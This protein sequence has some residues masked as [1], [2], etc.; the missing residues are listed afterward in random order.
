MT[1][2]H[3]VLIVDDHPLFRRGLVQLLQVIPAFHLVGEAAG[4]ASPPPTV[5]RRRRI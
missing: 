5:P 2:T 1:E 3:R 4:G